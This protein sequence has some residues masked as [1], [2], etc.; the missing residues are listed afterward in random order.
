MEQPSRSF[1]VARSYDF[2]YLNYESSRN[3][4]QSIHV[5]SFLEYKPK[6]HL[7]DDPISLVFSP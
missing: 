6:M 7:N 3:V 1:V 5:H 2:D 4:L